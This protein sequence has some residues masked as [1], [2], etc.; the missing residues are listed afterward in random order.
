MAI[1]W[2]KFGADLDDLVEKAGD[3]TDSRLAGKISSVTRLTDDEVKKLFPDPADVKRLGNLMAI[4]KH[5]DDE[6]KKIIKIAGNIKEFGGVILK[7]LTRL[8]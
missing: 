4:V 6:N 2:D 3:R 1:N 5:A 8:A 7:L